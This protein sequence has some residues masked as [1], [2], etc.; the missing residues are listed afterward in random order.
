[1]IGQHLNGYEL[2]EQAGRGDA[3]T[4]YVARQRPVERY[5]AV[6]VFDHLTTESVDRLR[7]LFDKLEALDHTNILPIYDRGET[8]DRIYWVMRYMPAG[9]L[10]AKL[11]G[12]RLTFDEIDRLITQVTGALD[13]A[14]QHGLVHGDLKPSNILLD[15]SG[16]AFVADF[17]LAGVLGSM[18]SDYQPP[19]LRR[20]SNPDARSDVYGLG[21]VLY[22][23][24]TGRPPN[25]AR[26]REEERINR[27]SVPPPPP[28]AINPKIPAVIDQVV[29]RALALDPDQRYQTPRELADA[30]LQARASAGEVIGTVHPLAK[31]D[32]RWIVPGIVGVLI[33]V[34]VIALWSSR[35]QVAA[36]SPTDTPVPTMT[37]APTA[38]PVIQPTSLATPIASPQP[39][40]SST[41]TV[42][43]S[44]VSTP[45]PTSTTAPRPVFSVTRRIPT[46]TPTLA[47]EPFT[48][49][50]P[51]Q[52]DA[53]TLGLS[54]GTRIQPVD[55]GPIGTLS[56]SIPAIEPYVIEHGLAQVG[57]GEQSLRVSIKVDCRK[58]IDPIITR[59]VIVLL[60]D[61][62]GK[63]L[64]SQ[65]FDYTKQWC[66]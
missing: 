51:R 49:L 31:I 28:S 20:A 19:E 37:I 42:L 64:L 57:S 30:Y 58:V 10:K 48:L 35:S 61:P 60:T 63:V 22:E 38:L 11:R 52:A 39:I 50:M 29:L 23:L 33:I 1:M 47:I 55:R 66:D 4:V 18:P 43:P 13:Y 6:K 17:G 9:S 36:P 16:H 8:D 27:R 65:T 2:L 25:D 26:A 44:S 32:R 46:A 34:G 56:M 21:A 14:Q 41:P 12:P 45:T 7:P 53:A 24:L 3:A 54:F 5:V 15:H 62:S 59:Q 40:P